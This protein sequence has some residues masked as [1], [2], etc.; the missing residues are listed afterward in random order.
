MT[1][2]RHTLLFAL[3]FLLLFGI[4]GFVVYE[5]W[6]RIAGPTITET[7]ISDGMSVSDFY[8]NIWA[9]VKNAEH[10]SINNRPVL[11]NTDSEI[12]DQIALA[13]GLNILEIKLVDHFGKERLY[14]YNIIADAD[15]PD[16]S[17]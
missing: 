8:I 3:F 6:P 7:N 11:A 13:P 5:Y 10:I 1:N 15:S 2:F 4:A 16:L 14:K 17:G 12:A 9:L